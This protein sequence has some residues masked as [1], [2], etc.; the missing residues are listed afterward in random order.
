MSLT[1]DESGTGGAT[2]ESGAKLPARSGGTAWSY[3]RFSLLLFAAV[4]LIALATFRDYGVSWDEDL[5][6]AYGYHVLDYY[7]TL[8]HDRTALSWLNL[9]YYGA[10]F[11]LVTAALAKIS[12]IGSYETRHLVDVA[13]GIVG[14]LGTWKLARFLAGPRA[15]FCA[16]ALLLLT[17]NYYGHMFN[18]PKDI[19][20]AA[21]TIWSLYYLALLL[22]A[23]PRPRWSLILRLG[24]AIGLG[25]G[26]RVGAL[27][28]ICY[29]GLALALLLGWRA[30]QRRDAALL[31]REGTALLARVVAPVIAIAYPIML[32]CWPW[33]QLDPLRNPFRALA[34]FSAHPFPYPTLFEGRYYPAPELPRDYLPVH[35]VLQL[36]ELVLVLL[37]AAVPLAILRLRRGGE[38]ATLIAGGIVG[39]ASLFPVVY[40]VAIHAVLFDGMR[41]FLFVLPPIACIAGMSLDALARRLAAPARGSLAAGLACYLA[42]HVSLMAGLYP[43][44][45]VYYNALAGGVP[46]AA[47]RFKLD[48]W[49]NSY[50]EAVGDLVARLKA[51][52]G[53]R[54]AATTYRVAVCGPPAS[55][56]YYFPKNFIYEADW[57]RA[58]FYIAFTKDGCNRSVPGR[59]MIRVERL[60][61]LLSAV[62]DLRR[63]APAPPAPDAVAQARLEE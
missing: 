35:I 40:A 15:G 31:W 57:R 19:P 56:R 21:A 43:D 51:V 4:A 58:D 42:L 11:D 6:F 39:V 25:L 53:R 10:A 28:S 37:L 46:G 47:G 38:P 9:Y 27:L 17:P 18:N 2:A 26:V 34:E 7:L 60:G 3:D 32:L 23:L 33:A 12:P 24:A 59:E 16:A 63:P 55:A 49:A 1:L 62:L 61:T 45:Y 20:F 50:R 30:W 14:V 13:I 36:P 44:E 54:F 52:D 22:P 8:F 5:H 48:Y 41:H 29:L